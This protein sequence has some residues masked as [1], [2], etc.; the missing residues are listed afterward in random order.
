MSFR[1]ICKTAGTVSAITALGL[2]G[3]ASNAYAAGSGYGGG[4]GGTP[5]GTG[6]YSQVVSVQTVTP[7]GGTFTATVDGVLLTVTV[8]PGEFSAPTQLVF[9]A[10]NLTQIS[11]TGVSGT[12]VAAFGIQFDQGGQKLSGP[13]PRPV[14][15][16]GQ[17]SKISASSVVYEEGSSGFSQ[18]P[19]WSSTAG[20]VVGSFSTDPDFA[21]A[22]PAASATA[23]PGATL[24]QTGEPFVGM[25]LAAGGL[26]VA[27]GLGF[28]WSR[29]RLRTVV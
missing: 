28:W 24:P 5:T 14:Q 22:T 25:G 8:P 12:I 15:V 21:I 9:T 19:G 16:T 10:G 3:L 27:G 23:V 17:S 7:A 6:A 26:V 1:C 4:T 13:F 11:T 29:R 20:E 18:A 2:I